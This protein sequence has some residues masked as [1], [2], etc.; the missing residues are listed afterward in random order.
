MTPT[1][2]DIHVARGRYD[3]ACAVGSEILDRTEGL[4]SV[5]VLRQLAI[6]QQRLEPVG[7]KATREFAG[8]LG[9]TLQE[10]AWWYTWAQDVTDRESEPDTHG[11][12][13]R[14]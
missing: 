11:G 7:A 3:E 9:A 1:L 4:S 5:R 14:P 8:R 12:P 13:N 6:L 10:R 2:A